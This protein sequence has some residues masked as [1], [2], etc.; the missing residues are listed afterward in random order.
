M[1]GLGT[2][3][4]VEIEEPGTGAKPGDAIDL[5]LLAEVVKVDAASA[6]VAAFPRQ[7]IARKQLLIVV[8]A[9]KGRPATEGDAKNEL[10]E[11][12]RKYAAEKP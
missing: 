8:M 4:I 10:A 6:Y 7:I 2:I 12:R 5:V 9:D 3:P 11:L 1:A